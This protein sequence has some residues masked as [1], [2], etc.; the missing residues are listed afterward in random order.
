[1][2]ASIEVNLIQKLIIL[3]QE[4]IKIIIYTQNIQAQHLQ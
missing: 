2:Q 1:M 3:H 4:L